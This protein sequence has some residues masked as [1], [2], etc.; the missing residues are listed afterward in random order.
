MEIIMR[1]GGIQKSGDRKES[2][3]GNDFKFGES[4]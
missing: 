2:L 1:M 3:Q 4:S